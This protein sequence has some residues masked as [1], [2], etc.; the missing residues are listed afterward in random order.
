MPIVKDKS[1]PIKIAINGYGRIGRNALRA[2]YEGDRRNH[3]QIVAVNDLGSAEINAHLTRY[4][5]THG[6]F[7]MK[8]SVD[9]DD[10]LIGGDRIKVLSQRDPKAIP[11][12][13]LDIDVV[14]ECTGRFASREAASNHLS[15]GAKRVIISA[16]AGSDVDATI[17]Y[18]VND[19]LLTSE[20]RIIAIGSCTTNC[21]AV[22]AK[23]LHDHIGIVAG[24]MTTVH[25]VTNDQVLTDVYHEDIR[26]ARSA[27]ASIIPTRTGAASAIGLVMPELQ[28]RLCGFSIRVPTIDVCLL[29][30]SFTTGRPTSADEI[31]ALMRDTAAGSTMRD[32]LK[33]NDVPLVSSDFLH[34]D[35][36]AIFD[37]TLT[38]VVGG[39]HATIYAWYDNEWGFANRL[40]D[41]AAMLGRAT[42]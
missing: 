34:D 17:V 21:L 24:T 25:A 42:L 20:H 26:R 27:M 41:N 9:G 32:I 38:K 6:K 30:L 29:I 4:D 15:A 35:A 7:P 14:L 1:M 23:P 39:T 18:G 31:N 33:V 37:T 12:K 2:L 22:V 11:W 28:G 3:M 16:P 36:S 8:V 13:D 10:M 19:S 5:T 40:L